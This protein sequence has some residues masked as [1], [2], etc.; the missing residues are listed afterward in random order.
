M[1]GALAARR[2]IDDFGSVCHAPVGM[3]QNCSDPETLMVRSTFER[4]SPVS[5]SSGFSIMSFGDPA[6]DARSLLA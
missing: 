3:K 2:F 1:T 5:R 4:T 6:K